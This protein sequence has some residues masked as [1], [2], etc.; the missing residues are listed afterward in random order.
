M[1]YIVRCILKRDF[2]EKKKSILES[3]KY[4]S[5]TGRILTKFLQISAISFTSFDVNN[6]RKKPDAILFGVCCH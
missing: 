4:G 6:R 3:T 5:K 1:P 2:N